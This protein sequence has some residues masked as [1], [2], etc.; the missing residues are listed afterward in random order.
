MTLFRGVFGT[1]PLGGCGGREF[2]CRCRPR[3]TDHP[4]GLPENSPVTP[5]APALAPVA[6]LDSSYRSLIRHAVVGAV[7]T[8]LDGR[9]LEANAQWCEMLGYTEAELRRLRVADVT[10]P[11]CLAESVALIAQLKAGLSGFVVEKRYVRKD[12]RAVFGLTNVTAVRDADGRPTGMLA[13]I[14]DVTARKQDQGRLEFKAELSQRL[15]TLRD[16][17]S[18]I[19]ATVE[20]VGRYLGAHRCHFIEC[21]EAQDRIIVSPTWCRD[22]A[23]SLEG[24]YSLFEFGGAEWW[25]RYAAGD[26]CVADVE[27]DPL[28]RGEAARRYLSLGVRSYAVQPFKREGPCTVVLGVTDIA[29]RQ[30]TAHERALLES[31]V[32]RVWPLVEHARAEKALAATREAAER[33]RRLFETILASSEDYISVTDRQHRFLYVNQKLA[34][35]WGR[36]PGDFIGCTLAQTGHNEAQVA[37]HTREFAQVIAS[38]APLR[39][40]VNVGDLHFEYILSPIVGEDGQVEAVA[41]VTRDVS[42]SRA[43]AAALRQ[44]AE[45]KDHFIALLAHELRNPLAPL[46]TGLEVARLSPDRGRALEELRPMM[47]RQVQHMV[48]LVE[49]LLDMS[50]LGLRKIELRRTRVLLANVV[51]HAVEAARPALESARQELR[52][53]LPGE[54]LHLEA[55]ITRLA[56][57]L[58]NLLHNSVKFTPAG[59]VIAIDAR[60]DG[61]EVEIA[62]SDNGMGISPDKLEGIFDL[63]SQGDRAFDR[64][65]GG[66][67]IGLALVKGLVEL[68]GGSVRAASA[69]PGRGSR[70]IVLLPLL[71]A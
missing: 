48:R 33:Q 4:P 68:H 70:F 52:V 16:E 49:D 65:A 26:F 35:F 24:T 27:S 40:E 34:R 15:A 22:G 42:A 62:V 37:Q 51:A 13:L 18:I 44:K 3:P 46:R 36:E 11:D 63:F 50:R 53:N 66:L 32:A 45:E 12:G 6:P 57:V 31:V 71:L 30:W 28:T 9:F 29:A 43:A 59:G 14:V 67:G 21:L 2:K 47:E 17:R 64:E 25:Q 39:S 19:E 56:Q 69:G 58:G 38:A 41:A 10:H 61:A 5:A 60:R 55:D 23:A 54:A 20:A 1:F 7:H 8:D